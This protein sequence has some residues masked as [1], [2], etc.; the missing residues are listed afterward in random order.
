MGKRSTALFVLTMVATV[1]CDQSTAPN[2]SAEATAKVLL[3][4]QDIAVSRLNVSDVIERL[5][6]SIGDDKAEA[7]LRIE[8]AAFESQLAGGDKEGARKSLSAAHAS[9][10]DLAERTKS[11]KFESADIGA[12]RIALSEAEVSLTKLEKLQAQNQQ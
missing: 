5:L 6:P 8:L 11:G 12:V 2:V 10:N 4:Q 7:R 9:L 1:S 3:P